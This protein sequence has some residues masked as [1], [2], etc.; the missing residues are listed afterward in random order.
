MKVLDFAAFK[1]LRGVCRDVL[2]LIKSFINGFK[3]Q[4]QIFVEFYWGL[5]SE[6]VDRF[7]NEKQEIRESEVLEIITVSVDVLGEEGAQMIS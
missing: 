6:S 5:V 2:L 4:K 3:N 1:R 7:I